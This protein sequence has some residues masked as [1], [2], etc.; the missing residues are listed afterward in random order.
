M[1]ISFTE[2]IFLLYSLCNRE[3]RLTDFGSKGNVRAKKIK[4]KGAEWK[5]IY[6]FGKKAMNDS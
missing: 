4:D 6:E 5:Y 1:Q 2:I 3:K